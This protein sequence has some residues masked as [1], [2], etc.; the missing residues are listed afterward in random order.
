[1]RRSQCSRNSGET[2]GCPG[3]YHDQVHERPRPGGGPVLGRQP[4][5]RARRLRGR[6]RGRPPQERDGRRGL[7]QV[8]P[9]LRRV[10]RVG[11]APAR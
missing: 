8:H 9:G 4:G 5:H 7:R 2:P 3:G 1:M 10:Q 6:G 11:Q